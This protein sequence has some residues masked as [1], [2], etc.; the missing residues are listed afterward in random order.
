ML[1]TCNSVCYSRYPEDAKNVKETY[2]STSLW[3]FKQEYGL[4]F[5]PKFALKILLILA[6][7]F[8]L[9]P[10]PRVNCTGCFKKVQ[11]SQVS[12]V[13]DSCGELYHV[14]CLMGRF[15]GNMEKFYCSLSSVNTDYDNAFDSAG[16]VPL[17]SQQNSHLQNRGLKVLHSDV[18]GLLG[19]IDQI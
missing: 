8:E 19:K 9:N 18:N 13:C 7:D 2:I 12:K 4:N 15:E 3:Q 16:N 6:G 17:Y 1:V 10:D 5:K 11:Q 14:K